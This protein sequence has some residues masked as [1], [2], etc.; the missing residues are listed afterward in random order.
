MHKPLFQ[1]GPLS[2]LLPS[3]WY[4]ATQLLVV[5][6]KDKGFRPNLSVIAQP[7]HEKLS[8]EQYAHAVLP[9]M[10]QGLKN[11]QLLREGPARLGALSGYR[12]EF[13]LER[14]RLQLGQLQFIAVHNELIWSFT[15]TQRASRLEENLDFAEELIGG[16]RLQTPLTAFKQGALTAS[17]PQPGPTSGNPRL[18]QHGDLSLPLPPDWQDATDLVLVGPEESAFRPN[19][20]I[21]G[22]PDP[23]GRTAEQCAQDALPGLRKRARDFQLLSEGPAQFG[24]LSGSLLEFTFEHAGTPLGQEQF[25]VVHEGLVWCFTYTQRAWRFQESRPFA[26]L[27]IGSAQLQT[28]L[29]AG[30]VR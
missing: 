9:A 13:T 22:R 30:K 5:G 16:V 21:L 25:F 11:F 26:K 3:G 1:H 7:D 19:L 20:T 4:D 28:P 24:A 10:R 17:P 2:L 14:D 8:A 27:L 29:P 12:L 23:R 18:F 15:Y 6:P